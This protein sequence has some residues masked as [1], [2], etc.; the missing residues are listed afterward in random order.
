[1]GA[2]PVLVERFRREHKLESS[3]YSVSGPFG[4]I[5]TVLEPSTA[6]ESGSGPDQVGGESAGSIPAQDCKIEGVGAV[7]ARENCDTQNEF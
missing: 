1:M 5:P 2:L 4:E 6:R 3:F 7:Q